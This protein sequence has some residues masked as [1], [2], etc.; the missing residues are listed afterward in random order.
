[1]LLILQEQRLRAEVKANRNVTQR[2]VN[3]IKFL[4][5]Q[6]L[7]KRGHRESLM[8]ETQNCGNFLELLKLLSQYDTIMKDHLEKVIQSQDKRSPSRELQK[9]KGRGSKLTFLSN[10]TQNKIIDIISSAIKGEISRQINDSLAWALMVDT[11]PDV[12]RQEQL[13]I[14][15]RIVHTNGTYS[16]H[17]LNCIRASGTKAF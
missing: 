7:A 12:S 1:M 16:E 13:I 4:G 5:R 8:Q 9:V 10:R 2:I 14:C 3:I 6:R 17:M 11:T 15:V